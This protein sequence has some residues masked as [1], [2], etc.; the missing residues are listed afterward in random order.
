MKLKDHLIAITLSA[1]IGSFFGLALSHGLKLD[2]TF[3]EKKT[4]SFEKSLT[5]ESF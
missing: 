5:K 3:E 1:I 2:E 4:E